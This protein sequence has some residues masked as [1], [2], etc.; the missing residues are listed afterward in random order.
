MPG[1]VE[2]RLGELA[3]YIAHNSQNDPNFGK[4]K[5][6]KLLAFTD[7]VS[8]ERRQRPITGAT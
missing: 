8:Y 2:L 6:V 5:L 3:L 7:F 1:D 4:T